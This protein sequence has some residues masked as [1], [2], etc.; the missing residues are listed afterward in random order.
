M[1]AVMYHYVRKENDEFPSFKFLHIDAF[2]KQ[3]DYLAENFGIL[4]PD[5]LKESVI[6]GKPADGVILTFDDGIKD[7]YDFVLPELLNRGLSAIFYIS[8]GVYE[9]NRIL[10]VHRLHLLLG[11]FPSGL[12]YHKLLGLVKNEMLSHSHVKEFQTIPY[13]LQNN[14][15]YTNQVKRMMNYLISYQYRE[16]VLDE[17]MDEFFGGDKK[18]FESFYLSIG[19]IKKMHDLGMVMGSHT[20]S[21][22]VLSKLSFQEQ[23]TEIHS[24]FDYLE[25]ICIKLPYKTFCYPYGGFHSFT[26]ETESILKNA[27]CLFSFNV[28]ERDI[29]EMDLKNRPQALPRY[30][31]NCFPHG[32]LWENKKVTE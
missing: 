3:L 23:Q 25:N 19:E 8:T 16:Q 11:K 20:K 24:S 9:S 30:D 22:P 32:K 29:S 12:I 2:K 15:E 13:S 28:E 14:D 4:H 31:C 17:L 21:H 1:K 27:G 10:G 18:I 7:H 26:N 6:T 5:V